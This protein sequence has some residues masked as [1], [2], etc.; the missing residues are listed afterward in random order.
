MKIEI[1][2]V[3]MDAIGE[4]KRGNSKSVFCIT[5]GSFYA[6]VTDAANTAGVSVPTMCQALS[7]K[8]RTCRGKRYCYV[9]DVMMHLDEI[10]EN[11]KIRNEKIAA[12]DAIVGR[13]EAQRKAKEKFENQKAKRE[14]LLAQLAETE[15]LMKEAEE[16]MQ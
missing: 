1:T 9:S 14:K 8:S 4:R 15:A 5:D 11:L 3:R 6:R 10:S 2:K 13:E 16:E 12:Y 7:G